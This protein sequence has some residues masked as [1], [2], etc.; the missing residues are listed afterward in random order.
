MQLNSEKM[1]Y[2]FLNAF[3]D[4]KEVFSR[5]ADANLFDFVDPEKMVIV[6]RRACLTY[7][8][9]IQ[10]DILQIFRL[11][12]PDCPLRPDTDLSRKAAED[13]A[14]HLKDEI[15]TRLPLLK[16]AESGEHR[17]HVAG[18]AARIYWGTYRMLTE[19]RKAGINPREPYY[20]AVK[21]PIS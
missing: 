17:S 1:K 9:L 14:L 18:I 5:N 11:L 20:I 3:P 6:A 15:R 19:N 2:Y 10:P 13:L 7:D 16:T 21:K 12:E 8:V 4:V